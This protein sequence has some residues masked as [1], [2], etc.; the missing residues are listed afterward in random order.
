MDVFLAPRFDYRF[1]TLQAVAC[2]AQPFQSVI[3]SAS[4]KSQ[5]I[6]T[7][8]LASGLSTLLTA[9]MGYR[10]GQI[11]LSNR[12]F[13]QLTSI[14]ASKT[15]QIESYFRNLQNH[16]QT[17]SEDLSIV[18]AV[19]KFDAAFK[20]LEKT[21]PSPGAAKAVQNDYINPQ[22][23]IV[24]TVFK[25]TDYATNLRTGPYKDSNL[26]RLV[27]QVIASQQKDF[28]RLEDFAADATS[29]GEPASFIAA[30]IHDGSRM[31]G[32]LAF[33]VP[34]DEINRVMT[35]NQQWEKDGLGDSGETILVGNDNLMRSASRFYL[36]DPKGF[37]AMLKSRGIKEE[38]VPAWVKPRSFTT[39]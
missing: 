36:E 8:L 26:A 29:Y 35:G 15:Y 33:Q 18:A 31:V 32:V 16:T 2:S 21:P 4:I 20:Q 7:F 25:E 17:L 24:Y 38:I 28:S 34:V 1:F 5:L 30:P 12:L 37:L 19:Q 9:L 39:L 27:S 22:G 6:L 3:G 11:N 23:E 14:R 13:N 10:I